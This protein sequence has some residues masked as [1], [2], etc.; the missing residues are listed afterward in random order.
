MHKNAVNYDELL[1]LRNEL[2]NVDFDKV[3]VKKLKVV[4]L[5]I[6]RYEQELSE[7]EKEN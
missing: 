7:N 6:A 2:Q 4:S 5:Q 3:D 1:K